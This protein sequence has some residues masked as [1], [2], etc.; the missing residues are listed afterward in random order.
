MMGRLEPKYQ[1]IELIPPNS[2]YCQVCQEKYDN[3]FEH[4]GEE[5]HAEL[6]KNNAYN[7]SILE[8]CCG[9]TDQQRTS[10]CEGRKKIKKSHPA[11][12]PRKPE[13]R[14]A[15]NANPSLNKSNPNH[16]LPMHK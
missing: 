5:E 8:L 14:A 11:A 3:Y 12:I 15:K 7:A 2:K 6:A 13:T 10:K 9:I 4:T 1:R 16:L